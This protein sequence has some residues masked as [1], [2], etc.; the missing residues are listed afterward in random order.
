MGEKRS[1]IPEQQNYCFHEA[2]L[3]EDRFGCFC[4]FGVVFSQRM[5][6]SSCKKVGRIWQVESSSPF[7]SEF[8]LP[9]S[10][11]ELSGAEVLN[12][13]FRKL[14]LLCITGSFGHFFSL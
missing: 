2:V 10:Q 9:P 8:S 5:A 4:S 13:V 11:R 7:S 6:E 3:T 12:K 1:F 14:D